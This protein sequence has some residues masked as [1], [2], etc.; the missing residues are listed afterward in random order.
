MNAALTL[1]LVAAALAALLGGLAWLGRFL[2]WPPE[3]RRKAAHITLGLGCAPF[4]WLFASPVPVWILAG[5]AAAGLGLLRLRV[6]RASTLGSALHDVKR[7]SWG[8]LVFP[9]AVALVFHASAGHWELYLPPLLVLALADAAG[10]LVGRRFGRHPLR[11]EGAQ[12]K[13]LEGCAAVFLVATLCVALPLALFAGW[14]WPLALAAALLVA[15]LAALVEGVA[16]EGLDN[17]FLPLLAYAVLARAEAWGSSGIL[18]RLAA[19]VLIVVTLAGLRRHLSALTDTALMGLALAL[20]LFASLGGTDWLLS[21]LALATLYVALHLRAKDDATRHHPLAAVVACAAAPLA[22]LALAPA[23][24]E[25]PGKVAL[26]TQAVLMLLAEQGLLTHRDPDLRWLL[27]AL[28]GAA[29]SVLAYL[30]FA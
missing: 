30:A 26:G 25:I 6:A 16:I 8:E 18:S 17:L 20:Y 13:S 23:H 28:I 4:P 3:L 10:A 9:L 1:A 7:R 19:L 2:A 29:V 24:A 21:P 15:G 12:H 11:M 14:A 5:L 22:W 27:N